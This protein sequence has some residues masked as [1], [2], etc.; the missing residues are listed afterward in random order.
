M[1]D[2]PEFD[3]Q[4]AHRY[5]STTCFNQAW[6]LI[7]RPG[8]TPDEDEEMLRLSLTS[9]WHWS[10]RPDCSPANLSIGM[11]QIARI[12][13]LLGQVENARRYGQLCLEIS[14]GAGIS[15]F[16]LGYAYEALA[17]VEALAGD[18][19]KM[20]QYLNEALR[21]AAHLTDLEDKE[22]L[23]ADLETIH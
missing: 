4:A 17:R 3:I 10:Q 13:T 12:Y 21:A 19:P 2:T 1:P 6:E 18:K 11:W 7:D 9:A 8:R 15:P 14:R 22:Q 5:F 23:I 20:E 16:Y